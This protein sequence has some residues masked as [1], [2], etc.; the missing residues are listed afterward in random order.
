VEKLSEVFLRESV[1]NNCIMERAF[2]S[3]S[4]PINPAMI[5]MAEQERFSSY[6]RNYSNNK[7]NNNNN[8]N[9]NNHDD[10]HDD[11]NED[12]DGNNYKKTIT[13]MII[14][15]PFNPEFFQVVLFS[16]S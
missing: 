7:N 6:L 5:S 3:D 12:D 4:F 15:I 10:D 16:T 8:N 9:N 2:S 14:I 13:I 11:D 1:L